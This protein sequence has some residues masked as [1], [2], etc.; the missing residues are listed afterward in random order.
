MSMFIFSNSDGLDKSC[1]IDTDCVAVSDVNVLY[2]PCNL[3]KGNCDDEKLMPIVNRYS[4]SNQEEHTNGMIHFGYFKLPKQI[5]C[6]NKKCK[7]IF[8]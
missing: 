4:K 5:I 3:S 8:E 1:N 2:F 7:G 6:E